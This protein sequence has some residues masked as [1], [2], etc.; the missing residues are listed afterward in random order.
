[1]GAQFNDDL[2][3]QF[4]PVPT[5]LA[6]GYKADTP[7]GLPGYSS[8]DLTVA[9][10]LRPNF[11]VFFGVQNLTDNVYFVQTNPSTIGTPRLVNAGIRIRFSGR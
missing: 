4:I 11:Q 1:M 5:L 10:D 2:N 8:V 6:E 3:V 7:A 9:R